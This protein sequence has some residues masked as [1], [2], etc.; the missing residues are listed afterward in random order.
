ME[1]CQCHLISDSNE[2]LQI[3]FS[4]AKNDS[5]CDTRMLF[6][7]RHR[8]QKVTS[9]MQLCKLLVAVVY[10][11]HNKQ[12][13]KYTQKNNN[14][15]SLPILSISQNAIHVYLATAI[16][17]ATWNAI[18]IS[19]CQLIYDPHCKFV[20]WMQKMTAT[21]IWEYCSLHDI[22]KQ[23]GL[24]LRLRPATA[25]PQVTSIEDSDLF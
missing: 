14:L 19:Y 6:A 4:K 16:C 9:N 18:A 8:H 24:R 7:S 23:P 15:K 22:E 2:T 11:K 1:D 5:N 20:S 17:P 12:R 10:L 21:A 25:S 3:C 13:T